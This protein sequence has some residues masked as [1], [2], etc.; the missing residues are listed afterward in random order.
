MTCRLEQS[1]LF[2]QLPGS[3]EVCAARPCPSESHSPPASPLPASQAGQVVVSASPQ[4]PPTAVTHS[5]VLAQA[6]SGRGADGAAWDI[7]S[8]STPVMGRNA[9]VIFREFQEVFG[10]R[11][12]AV[13]HKGSIVCLPSLFSCAQVI[14]ADAIIVTALA[15]MACSLQGLNG[16]AKVEEQK[17]PSLPILTCS[18]PSAPR[19]SS[20]K[21]AGAS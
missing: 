1:C 5:V 2:P 6:L 8:H 14:N 11:R 12:P 19:P 18:V 9:H 17:L 20:H 16:G 4:L 13:R 15:G 21:A 3:T 7:G 10:P